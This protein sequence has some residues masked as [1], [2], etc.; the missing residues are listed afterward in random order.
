MPPQD[1]MFPNIHLW[2]RSLVGVITDL[3]VN[4]NVA[5]ST[6][7]MVIGLPRVLLQLVLMD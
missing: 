4:E 2:L 6:E 1:I 7:E 3:E 5:D